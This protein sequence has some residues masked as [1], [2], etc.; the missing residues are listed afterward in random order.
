MHFGYFGL[1]GYRERGIPASKVF[2]EH[3]EQVRHADQLGFETAWFAEHHFS[4]YCICPSPLIM[5]AHCAGKTDRIKLAP[6]VLVTP[7]YDPARLLAEIGMAD[8]L[9]GG[10]LVLGLGSGYQPYEFER[11]HQ[12]LANARPMLSEFIDMLDL[13]F[14]EDTFEYHGEHYDLPST[15]ISARPVNGLPEIW[16]AGDHE[17][18]HRLCARKGYVPMFT[19]RWLGADYQRQQRE[20]IAK[21]Y[22]A[23]GRDPDSMPLAVQRFM[24][25]TKTREETLAYV[26]N[27]RH[28]MR[29]ASALRRRAE[30]TDGAMMREIPI[31]DEPP[32]EEIADQLLVGDCETIAE[33]LCN[34]IQACRPLHM[35]FHFQVGASAHAHAL[36]TMEKLMTDIKPMVEKELGPLETLGQP[37]ATAQRS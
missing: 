30:V 32:L 9:S 2:E 37:T 27:A 10:R 4:N 5:V 19:G 17:Y 7:L 12:E 28:Q 20:Y 1:M 26:D 18:G 16:I 35:M 14:L 24:G 21:S 25:V 11:F 15:H 33:R 23:E 31:P 8:C 13:A 22:V 29:L 6:A 3:V 36:M 34:E